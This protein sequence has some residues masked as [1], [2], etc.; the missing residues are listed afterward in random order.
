M[1]KHLLQEVLH[2]MPATPIEEAEDILKSF[3][4]LP[5]VPAA[6]SKAVQLLNDS[7]VDIARVADIILADQVITARVIRIIN[8]PL[9]MLLQ[10]VDSVRKAL[11]YLGPQKIFEIIITSCFLELTD[12]RH[13]ASGID[14]CWEH[15][16]GVAL[17]AKSLAEFSGLEKPENAYV[18]GIVHDIGEVVLSQ[19]RPDDFIQLLK[20]ANERNLDLY[21]AEMEFFGASHCEVGALLARHWSFPGGISEV[22]LH[23]HDKDVDSMSQLVRI[24][25]LADMI[26]T[27]VN[28]ASRP[29]GKRY[30]LGGEGPGINLEPLES[31]LRMLGVKDLPEFSHF[32]ENVVEQVRESVKAVYS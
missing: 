6:A 18:A 14:C 17:V 25:S 21:D 22:I 10:E 12:S 19:Q 32:L 28:L 2:I 23:H 24:V 3:R 13:S 7:D 27:D 15:S 1:A 8:S 11:I 31:Q 20:M 26:C 9:Y 5:T 30:C 29:D 16:F 4:V